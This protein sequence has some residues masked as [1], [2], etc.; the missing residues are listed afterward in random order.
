MP[1]VFVIAA[2]TSNYAI[3]KDNKLVAPIKADMDHFVSHTTGPDKLVIS[4]RLNYESFPKRPLPGRINGVVTRD[5]NYPVVEGMYIAPSLEEALKIAY[6]TANEIYIIGGGQI[7]KE[8]ME[9]PDMVDELII[10]H[11]DK[12]VEDADVFF[13]AI[14]PEI[15]VEAERSEVFTT[16]KGTKYYFARYVRK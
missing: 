5:Q 7:Y 1:K 2:I 12:V 3:G 6:V 8:A 16:I 15:W 10:T 13:P 4:G 14:D 11:I 9:S